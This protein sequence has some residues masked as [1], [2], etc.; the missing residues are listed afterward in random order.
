[1]DGSGKSTIVN[2]LQGT[3]PKQ[4]IIPTIGFSIHRIT[5]KHLTFTCFDMSGQG[6]YRNL[7]EHYYQEI[8]G[9][10]FVVDSTDKLRLL[11]ASDEM[12]QLLSHKKIVNRPIPLL[13]LANKKDIGGAYTASQIAN[14]LGLANVR[15]RPWNI[16]SAS[17]LTG[18]GMQN[19]M[20]WFID[21]VRI[22]LAE[23]R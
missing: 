19:S 4:I 7:W 10:I 13:V 17:A 1:M 18:E 6:R 22:Y 12:E 3:C 2:H 23:S 16:S 11:V 15:N 21:E 20:S 14:A 5:L 9:I 8:D